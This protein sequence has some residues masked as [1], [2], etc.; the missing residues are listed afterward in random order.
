MA[1]G[2]NNLALCFCST[3]NLNNIASNW[4]YS[5]HIKSPITNIGS[6]APKTTQLQVNET[7]FRV[8]H[9][10]STDRQNLAKRANFTKCAL[11]ITFR[12]NYSILISYLLLNIYY[13]SIKWLNKGP[14]VALQFFLVL[15]AG[16]SP[17]L[18]LVGPSQPWQVLNENKTRK[19][20]YETLCPQLYA[21][22]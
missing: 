3:A 15:F 6:T 21:C 7:R 5:L 22:P 9:F 18:S 2:Q 4:Q 12:N 16:I 1:I 19:C 17:F 11:K 8:R 13:Y 20:V 14:L 10:L